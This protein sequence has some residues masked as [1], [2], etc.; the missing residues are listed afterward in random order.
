MSYL[1]E[2]PPPALRRRLRAGYG[3]LWVSACN[4]VR[5]AVYMS[6]VLGDTRTFGDRPCSKSVLY[7]SVPFCH[8]Q[9]V[10]SDF[11]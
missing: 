3:R 5:V 7:S 2:T 8:Q 1:E 11:A 10:C 4:D 9:N 6:T